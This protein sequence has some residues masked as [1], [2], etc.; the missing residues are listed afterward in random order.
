MKIQK[1]EIDAFRGIPDKRTI[2]FSDKNGEC[3]SAIIYGGNGSGKSSIVDAIEYNL[4]SRIERS[5]SIRNPK[6]PFPI[7]FY[8]ARFKDPSSII[9]FEDNSEHI[10]TIQVSYDKYKEKVK[11]QRSPVEPHP[12]FCNVPLVLRR[13]DIISYNNISEAERQK[14]IYQFVYQASDKSLLENDPIVLD[15]K[16]EIIALKTQRRE[17]INKLY[18]LTKITEEE[19]TKNLQNLELFIKTRITSHRPKAT[20]NRRTISTVK[21]I[22]EPKLF[23]IIIQEVKIANQLTQQISEN[24]SKIKEMIG[25][26]KIGESVFSQLNDFYEKA[27]NYLNSAFKE[28]SNVNY[29]DD[30]RLSIGRI[31]AASL[32]IEFKLQNGKTVSPQSI[33]SEANFDLMIL[34]LYLSIIRVGVDRGQEKIIILDDVLQS[35]DSSIRALFVNYILRELKDWQIIITCHDRLWLNQL[36]HLFQRVGHKYKEFYINSWS[37]ATGPNIQEQNFYSFDNTLKQA[38]ST[39]DI[40]IIASISGLFL[41]KICQELSISIN[42]SIKRRVDDKYTIGDLWP[43]IKKCFKKTDLSQIIEDIDR[44]LYIRNL[45]GCHYNEWAEALNDEEVFLFAESVQSFYEKVFCD[46]C[47]KWISSVSSLS[48]DYECPCKKLTY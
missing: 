10:R 44:L 29:V 5:T 47:F 39:K 38:I 31:S 46:N 25:T 4:Q 26:P 36:R 32:N 16:D 45:L 24:Q 18:K 35:V 27:S 19:L 3:C 17:S 1:I 33:F 42:C 23:K 6:R 21:Q 40:R 22:V 12:D 13:N 11:F 48:S 28:I 7:N 14:L 2:N 20:Y 37:F 30:I 9:T 43:G 15:I 8:H 34:L 41:E